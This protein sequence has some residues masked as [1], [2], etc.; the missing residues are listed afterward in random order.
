[1]KLDR[2]TLVK[3]GIGILLLYVCIHFWPAVAVLL[4]AL[5]KAAAPLFIGCI[6]AYILNIPMSAFERIF[7]PKSQKKV[8]VKLRR[9]IGILLSFVLV[10]GIVTAV[11]WLVVPKLIECIELFLSE[12]PNTIMKLIDWA[13]QRGAFSPEV[14]GYLEGMN[15]QNYLPKLYNAATDGVEWIA[16]LVSTVFSGVVSAVISVIF[17]IYLLMGK[18]KLKRQYHALSNRFLREKW[19]DRIDYVAAVMHDCFHRYIV[20]QC[21]EALI[22]GVLCMMGMWILRIPY[23][24]MVGAL[25]A[26]TALIPVAGAFIGGGVG[27]FMILTTVSPMKALVFIIFLVILQQLEN[28]IIYPKVV[29]NSLR[30]PALWVLAAV[31]VGGGV[32]KIGGMILGVPLAAAIYRILGEHVYKKEEPAEIPQEDENKSGS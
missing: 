30:L 1:M 14:I 23:A 7:F 11:V 26:V 16:A 17:A 27:A 6:I 8:V 3:I 31:T 4:S 18:E 10:I 29:G 28:N 22:L 20:G 24:E 2:K 12:I 25:I 21:T 15:W 5:L 19:T 13:E 32:F 9:P